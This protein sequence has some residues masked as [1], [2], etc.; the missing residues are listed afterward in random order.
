MEAHTKNLKS[1]GFS[2]KNTNRIL[3]LLPNHSELEPTQ[4]YWIDSIERIIENNPEK[5]FL[6]LDEEP[7]EKG[8]IFIGSCPNGDPVAVDLND[9]NLPVY[10]LS[11]EEM[12]DSPIENIMEEV[13]KTIEEFELLV[14]KGTMPFDYFEI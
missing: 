9:D 7:R 1:L 10:Y 13:S 4:T 2:E 14:Q 6:G 5:N 11:H 12:F 8:I 3:S